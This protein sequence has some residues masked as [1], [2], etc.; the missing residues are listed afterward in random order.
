MR[1]IDEV[2]LPVAARPAVQTQSAPVATPARGP[3]PPVPGS[4]P[5]RL[6]AVTA[7]P[8][9]SDRLQQLGDPG[10][11]DAV[12]A[13]D[14][15]PFT[16]SAGGGGARR[17]LTNAVL[18]LAWLLI[19]SPA[20]ALHVTLLQ[21]TKDYRRC[22]FRR[23]DFSLETNRPQNRCKI[24]SEP[25]GRRTH[26]RRRPLPQPFPTIDIPVVGEPCSRAAITIF[27]DNHHP[28]AR[29]ASGGLK[30]SKDQCIVHG[31]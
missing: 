7:K 27:Q 25:H 14:L 28:F 31:S 11:S 12:F 15:M 4:A 18:H 26:W 30:T 29:L 13:F 17:G 9:A 20:E 21:T 3:P 19:Y 10:P 8:S 24:A 16:A 2:V 22:S 5:G 6:P 23:L 1:S